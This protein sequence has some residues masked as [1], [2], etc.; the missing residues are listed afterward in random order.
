M[1]DPN[2]FRRNSVDLE[3]MK[4]NILMLT[5]NDPAG[6]G[7]AFCNAINA[8]SENRCRL[9]TTETRYNFEFEKD[10]HIPD[11][12]DDGF[13]E[14]EGLLRDADIFHFHILSDENMTLGP[15]PVKDY[16]KGK[17]IL[18]H[19]HGHPYFQENYKFYRDKYGKLKRKVIVSTPDL[20]KLLPDATWI[21]NIVPIHNPLYMPDKQRKRNGTVI[22]GH[23]PTRQ[24]LKKTDVFKAVMDRII[25]RHE[26]VEKRIITNA[27]HK[28]CLDLKRGCDIFFDQ[29]G[30]S[31]GVSSLE[32][33]SQG[34]PT[35]A[36]LDALNIKAINEFTGSSLI[37]WVNVSDEGLL[38][39]SIERL[40]NNKATIREIGVSARSFMESYWHE[41]RILDRLFTVYAELY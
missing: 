18:H 3:E 41:K 19:H 40:I 7:I 21:P 31:F 34:I 1:K 30:P 20:L 11:L 22:V 12:A 39:N 15:L 33:L 32:S 37:P 6:M 8:Y 38:E 10:I 29:L 36:R 14:V 13:D 2:D 28:T 26:Q 9:I 4:L 23:S 16:A 17:A 25:S 5:A 35:L 24:D 27:L